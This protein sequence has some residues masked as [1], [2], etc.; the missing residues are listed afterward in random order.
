MPFSERL[1]FQ[2]S[3]Y[4]VVLAMSLALCHFYTA[5]HLHANGQFL[6]GLP[7]SLGAFLWLTVVLFG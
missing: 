1:S 7:V 4:H 6:L 5:G 2:G 3:L